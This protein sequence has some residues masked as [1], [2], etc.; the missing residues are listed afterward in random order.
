[1]KLEFSAGGIIYKKSGEDFQF[2]LILDGFNKWTFPKGHIENKEK[3]EIAALR[4]SEEELGIKNLKIVSQLNKI[5][6]WFKD[7]EELIHKFVYFY[8]IEAPTEAT[9][10]PQ[11]DEVKD[12]KWY[13]YK[14]A[15]EIIDYKKENQKILQKAYDLLSK[16]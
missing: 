16:N 7:K 14:E 2:A 11:E 12:A 5:N 1:M 8:L 15:L 6:Y 13:N 9:L 4:E 10:S 3:P